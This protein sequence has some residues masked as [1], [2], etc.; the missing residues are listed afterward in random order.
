MSE[1]T[2]PGAVPAGKKYF[3]PLENN[4][5]VF[6]HLVHAL[7][8]SP[9]LAF[10]DVYTIDEPSLLALIPRP[11]Y[12]LIFIAPAAVWRKRRVADLP[13]GLDITRKA[14]LPEYDGVG[15]TEPVVWFKQT[16]GHACGLIALLHSVANG[17]AKAHIQPDSTLDKLIAAAVPL[18]VHDRAQLLY[19]SAELEK[20]HQ[21]AAQKG[22][23]VAPRAE[24][25][26]G[27]HFISFVRGRDGHLWELEGGWNGPIDRGVL[28]EDDDMLSER[29]LRL[30]VRPFLEAAEGGVGLDEGLGF[31]IVALSSTQ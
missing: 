12:S 4:P 22:D 2:D 11:V 25:P 3:I 31:S 14:E 10:S 19:D 9:S 27:F 15:D 16:I 18:K 29:A 21:D 30:G 24:E 6:T 17:P 1:P 28:G 13:P 5:S 23:T 26:N 20:A 7:G 8:V